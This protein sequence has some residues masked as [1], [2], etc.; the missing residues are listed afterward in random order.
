MT[1]STFHFQR[2][3]HPTVSWME[4]E[5]TSFSGRHNEETPAWTP[6]YVQKTPRNRKGILTLEKTWPVIPGACDGA[7]HLRPITN[8]NTDQ[9]AVTIFWG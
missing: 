7:K 1:R 4:K 3:F 5:K 2:P 6:K 9:V 8:V